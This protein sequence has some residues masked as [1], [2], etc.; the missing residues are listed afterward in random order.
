MLQVLRHKTSEI[1]VFNEIKIKYETMIKDLEA[2]QNSVNDC[3]TRLQQKNEVFLKVKSQAT[4]PN[5]Q[6]EKVKQ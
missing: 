2:L 1:A 3:K 4:K 5:E 6:N